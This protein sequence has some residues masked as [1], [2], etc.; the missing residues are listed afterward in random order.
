SALPLPTG[1]ATHVFEVLA[2]LF[3]GQLAIGRDELWIPRRW[4]NK[5]LGDKSMKVMG[6]LLRMVRR[7]ERVSRPR[8][9]HLVDSR[10]GR[11]VIGV[12]MCVFV[13][14]A[15]FS[16]PF[17]GLDTLPSLGVVLLALGLI[18]GDVAFCVAGTVIGVGGISLSITVGARIA[19]AL[20]SW[21]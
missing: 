13:M 8:L 5:E 6:W 7:L 10:V 4:E 9:A 3:A 19:R 12:L 16:P 18:L 1:G 2:F 14:G 11:S 21:L 17:S 20:R 15:F